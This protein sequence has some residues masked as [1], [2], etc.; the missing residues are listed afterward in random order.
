MI[1]KLGKMRSSKEASSGKL[2]GDLTEASRQKFGELPGVKVVD[3]NASDEE[4]KVKGKK[5]PVVMVTG[6]IRKLAE[7]NDGADVVYSA[8]VEYIVHR[9]PEQAIAG[10]VSGSASAHA[11]KAEAKKRAVEFKRMVLAAAVES[12]VRRAPEALAAATR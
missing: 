5:L 10:T 6:Q 8:S 3:E 11:S 9:M 7:S 4:T 2:V 1:V 12:A